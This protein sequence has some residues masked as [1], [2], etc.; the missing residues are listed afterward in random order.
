MS[1]EASRVELQREGYS[2]DKAGIVSDALKRFRDVYVALRSAGWLHAQ[3][4]LEESL[5]ISR[6]AEHTIEFGGGA[7]VRGILGIDQS[8]FGF[9]AFVERIYISRATAR[10]SYPRNLYTV[11]FTLNAG[12]YEYEFVV[13][14]SSIVPW[15]TSLLRDGALRELSRGRAAISGDRLEELIG[16][17]LDFLRE[18]A[19]IPLRDPAKLFS[20]SSMSGY[21]DH[22]IAPL[23]VHALVELPGGHRILSIHV[24]GS[25][26]IAISTYDPST[27]PPFDVMIVGG[28]PQPPRYMVE[29]LRT[30]TIARLGN[31]PEVMH[32]VAVDLSELAGRLVRHSARILA[33]VSLFTL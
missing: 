33:G 29:Y 11:R 28:D 5:N 17:M 20:K 16:F 32:G 6:H 19:Q 2:L 9:E 25:G 12:V 10:W 31:L 3:E 30:Q 7:E 8:G 21:E 13:R 14:Y 22:G 23:Y 15:L 24:Y 1:E 18:P 27:Q 4:K 26:E